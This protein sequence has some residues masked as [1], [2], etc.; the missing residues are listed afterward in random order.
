MRPRHWVTANGI[1]LQSFAQSR[2]ERPVGSDHFAALW[3]FKSA[4]G[5]PYT[6]Y[7]AFSRKTRWICLPL[8]AALVGS[9]T[10]YAQPAQSAERTMAQAISTK[11]CEG[12]SAYK[13]AEKPPREHRVKNQRRNTGDSG[14]CQDPEKGRQSDSERR[15][16]PNVYDGEYLAGGLFEDRTC[17]GPGLRQFG[18]MGAR[19]F[20]SM[21]GRCEANDGCLDSSRA[22]SKR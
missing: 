18:T 22:N 10:I 21:P 3:I 8:I 14:S 19:V 17:R 7:V 6:F 11:S 12:P 16:E 2:L 1:W 20:V 4:V 15:C 9:L 13:L 5:D